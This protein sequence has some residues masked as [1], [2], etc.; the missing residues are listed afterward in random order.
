MYLK[1]IVK[2]H[3]WH[4]YTFLIESLML[5]PYTELAFMMGGKAK[6]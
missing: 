5:K 2:Q 1:L 4:I 6:Q 3:Q